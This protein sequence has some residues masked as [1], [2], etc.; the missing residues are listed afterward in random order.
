MIG[1]LRAIWLTVVF[2][3]FPFFTQVPMD[4]S[5]LRSALGNNPKSSQNLYNGFLTNSSKARFT[6]IYFWWSSG[7]F[8]DNWVFWIFVWFHRILASNFYLNFWCVFCIL[9]AIF[10]QYFCLPRYWC[11]HLG[12]YNWQL[13]YRI[14]GLSLR[15]F[16]ELFRLCLHG[17]TSL[18]LT[19]WRQRDF[20]YIC[21]LIKYSGNPSV[22][23]VG[24]L[25][26]LTNS[27]IVW[28]LVFF[29]V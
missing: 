15:L 27:G 3:Y 26:S 7:K 22:Y 9:T 24:S 13:V 6:G 19:F 14:S 17:L 25:G 23:F 2:L 4:N 16:Q 11:L 28:E 5:N 18:L 20:V 12:K 21:R 29:V 10:I 1:S 8:K